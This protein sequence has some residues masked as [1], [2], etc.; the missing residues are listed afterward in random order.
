MIS[1]RMHSPIRIAAMLAAT[2]AAALP[3]LPARADGT[4]G[5]KT[6]ECYCTDTAGDR[7]EIGQMICLH[8]DGKTFMA[9]CEMAL[10]VPIWRKVSGEC[11]TSSLPQ[12]LQPT[13][14]ARLVHTHVG[15]AIAQPRK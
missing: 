3:A 12:R 10:N 14:H 15:L 13:R 11:V 4:T 8:V 6:V 9:R 1:L 5:G 7:V 2:C